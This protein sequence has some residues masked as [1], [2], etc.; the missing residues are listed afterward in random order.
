MLRPLRQ[1]LVRRLS[2]AAAAAAPHV[3]ESAIGCAERWVRHV[4]VYAPV[5]GRM[6]EENLRG[7]GLFSRAV[8]RA[9]F[10]E[11]ALHYGNGLRIFGA[12][13]PEA[14]RGLAEGRVVVDRSIEALP[15]LLQQCGGLVIAPAHVCNYLLTLV[16]LNQFIPLTIYL[17]W[18]KD[19]RRRELKERW[20]RAAGL[21]VILE[22]PSATDPTSRAAACVEAVRSGRA[23]VMTPDLAM[24]SEQ[25]LPV[26]LL[27]RSVFLPVGPASIA[28]LAGVPLVPVFG[29]SVGCR[30]HSWW[31]SHRA[32]A[33][34]D[35]PTGPGGVHEPSVPHPALRDGVGHPPHFGTT[36]RRGG[37]SQEIYACD[38]IR[39][40]TLKR[41]D[42]GRQAG[43]EW[44]TQRWTDCFEAYLRRDPQ[45]W[46]FWG[47]KHWSRVFHGDP[48]YVQRLSE[49]A[50]QWPETQRPAGVSTFG[51]RYAPELPVLSRETEEAR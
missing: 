34:R 39:V 3:P 24:R 13:G 40:P 51:V 41:E 29:R 31:T 5:L 23:L 47:D 50:P 26:T 38:P 32:T 45:L 16:R 42:G 8:Q 43:L 7:A 21:Q 2:Y 4:L 25:G 11:A 15:S 48:R 35:G 10:A 46:F 44:A 20:C 19:A 12:A 18:S 27:G 17:R 37:Q 22:P 1:E 9:Y 14:V 28:M 49:V 36:S 6:V 33:E 30:A